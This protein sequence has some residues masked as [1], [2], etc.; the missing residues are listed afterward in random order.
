MPSQRRPGTGI[1]TAPGVGH[2]RR[3]RWAGGG[4]YALAPAG[5][6]P[7][8]QCGAGSRTAIL[9][10]Q[11]RLSASTRVACDCGMRSCAQLDA[12]LVTADARWHLQRA[13]QLPL[14]GGRAELFFFD[15]SPFVQKYYQT[16]WADRVGAHCNTLKSAVCI[17]RRGR[18]WGRS[19]V[20]AEGLNA[21]WCHTMCCAWHLRHCCGACGG[22]CVCQPGKSQPSIQ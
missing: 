1:C 4:G 11:R 3:G 22:A 17:A 18:S 7:H 15:T 9:H 16:A 20:T 5:S 6:V 14:A 2:A 21:T 10:C 19:S 13:Y 8:Q 12:A